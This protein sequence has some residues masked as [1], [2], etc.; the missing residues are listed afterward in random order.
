MQFITKKF[1]NKKKEL[2]TYIFD[3]LD[4]FVNEIIKRKD[5]NYWNNYVGDEEKS[6]EIIN[7]TLYG[8]NEDFEKLENNLKM[9]EKIMSLENVKHEENYYSVRGY[10]P[11]M[12]RYFAGVPNSMINH[13][14]STIKK[15]I[16]NILFEIDTKWS[17][18]NEQRN[19]KFSKLLNKIINLE[20]QGYRI[21]LYLFSS[22]EDLNNFCTARIIKIKSADE[23]MSLNRFAYALINSQFFRTLVFFDI[24][25]FPY[26][27]KDIDKSTLG[28][29][30]SN[31][32][33]R[34]C[35]IKGFAKEWINSLTDLVYTENSNVL[36]VNYYTDENKFLEEIA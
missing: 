14:T 31:H 11:C 17:I 24:A 10:Q 9:N 13:R 25:S 2:A 12:A 26:R 33:S 35:D 4:E 19:E 18:T 3:S 30:L 22:E 8:S 23:N 36:L 21:S 32:F 29:P 16:V 28:K 7:K 6:K 1:F 5:N 20:N 27:N 34:R 15:K